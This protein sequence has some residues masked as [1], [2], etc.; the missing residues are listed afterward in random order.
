MNPNW[1]DGIERV[2]REPLLFKQKLGIG[3]DAYKSLSVAGATRQYWDLFSAAGSGAAL[4]K[5][6]LIAN[7]FFQPTGIMAFLGLASATTPVGWAVFAAVASAG[8]WYGIDS[9]YKKARN[10]R[11]DVIPKFINTPIDVI[12][13]S[14]FNL[15]L[16]LSLKV[17]LADGHFHESEKDRIREYFIEEWGYDEEFYATGYDLF[18]GD[19]EKFDTGAL[20]KTLSEFQKSNPD[21]NQKFITGELVLFLEEVMDSD[22]VRHENEEREIQVIKNSAMPKSNWMDR[23]KS[24]LPGTFSKQE[25]DCDTNTAKLPGGLD[26]LLVSIQI[27]TDTAAKN[28]AELTKRVDD[29]DLK[30]IRAI[31]THERM[32]VDLSIK[33][34]KTDSE[35][36]ALASKFDGI[37]TQLEILSERCERLEARLDLSRKFIYVLSFLTVLS[38][39]VILAKM[40]GLIVPWVLL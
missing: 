11:I 15:I 14:L 34:N 7:A 21:C 6:A 37:D 18:V 35:L 8:A 23:M 9:Y 10:E 33:V 13:V 19:I 30:S 26:Q 29:G 1:H 24:A 39:L 2:I 5:S 20:I 25:K 16:P 12:G 40:F 3:E 27:K 22:G 36:S 32:L 31:S 17:A 28:L 38:V 4:A